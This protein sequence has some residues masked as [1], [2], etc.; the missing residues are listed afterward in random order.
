M[1]QTRVAGVK[2]ELKTERGKPFVRITEEET[3]AWV[4]VP[5]ADRRITPTQ[6]RRIA[7]WFANLAEELEE[8]P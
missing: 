3:S 1:K 7:W 4:S 2:L 5:I 8:Q 6:A